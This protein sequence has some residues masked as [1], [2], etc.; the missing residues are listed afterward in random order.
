[1]NSIL[2]I[3][4]DDTKFWSNL[5]DYLSRQPN[6]GSTKLG[7]CTGFNHE[8]IQEFIEGDPQNDDTPSKIPVITDKDIQ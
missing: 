6:D 2:I 1:M 3:K 5:I 7:C 4:S 8:F